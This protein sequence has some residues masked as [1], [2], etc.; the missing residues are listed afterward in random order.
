MV[1]YRR[2]RYSYRPRRY[3]RYRR[4]TYRRRYRKL[5]TKYRIKRKFQKEVARCNPYIGGPQPIIIPN[6]M[7]RRCTYRYTINSA[8]ALANYFSPIYSFRANSIFD[9]DSSGVGTTATCYSDL[10]AKYN[11]YIVHS[12]KIRWHVSV[13]QA[14]ADLGPLVMCTCL[15]DDATTFLAT[16]SWATQM[17]DPRCKAQRVTRNVKEKT[18]SGVITSRYN[19]KKFFL[20]VD[21]EVHGARF[22][23][24]P[25]VQAF[26]TMRLYSADG[27]T[28]LS[29][30]MLF[31]DVEYL[32]EAFNKK[33]PLSYYEGV[34]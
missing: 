16:G 18:G 28:V 33:G 6:S 17:S 30:F 23:Y 31:V 14:G 22:G 13:S 25:T 11:N 21:N 7:F 15:D 10:S 4:K 34:V 1:S 3:R 19:A 26:Y 2:R 12:S 27:I 9:P 29:P 24:N 8:A 20:D 5:K 32:V